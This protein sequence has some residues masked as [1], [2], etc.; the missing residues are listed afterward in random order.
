M[1]RSD[2]APPPRVQ[3]DVLRINRRSAPLVDLERAGAYR[4]LLGATFGHGA[5]DVSRA[6]RPYVTATQVR[7]LG[8]DLGFAAHAATSQLTFAQWLAVF[9]FVEHECL[10]RDP[11]RWAA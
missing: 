5:G 9:R 2:F 4:A 3:S 7:R 11:T 10:G 1:R 8:R 6:L